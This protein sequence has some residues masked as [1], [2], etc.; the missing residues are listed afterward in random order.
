MQPQE[1]TPVSVLNVGKSFGGRRVLD[2]LSL[3]V[4]RGNIVGLLG[5]NGSGKTTLLKI[6]LG[7][8]SRDSGTAEICG[9]NVES[10]PPEI[11]ER[12]GY[13]PQSSQLFAWLTGR[14]MLRYVG[15]FYPNYDHEYAHSVAE[16]LQ[17]SLKTGIEALS[18]GQQQR[19]SI[20]RALAT[21]PDILVLDEPMAALDPAARIFVIE[22]LLRE[23]QARNVTIIVSSHIVH[24]L[25][26][27]CTHLAV[28]KGGRVAIHERVEFFSGLVRIVARGEESMLASAVF[29]NASHVRSGNPGE[30]SLVVPQGSMAALERELPAGITLQHPEGDLEA[31]L[32]EWMR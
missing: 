13:V 20:V 15:S 16:R 22:E 25:Q 30:R 31:V 17:V 18:P 29:A 32:S 28:V 2:E 4:E 9:A 5:A 26:R 6:M 27:Y 21:R 23:H 7:L 12:I 11:R 19:L 3:R 1:I 14:A 8:L 24:D 10:L